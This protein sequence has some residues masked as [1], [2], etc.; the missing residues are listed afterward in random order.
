VWITAAALLQCKDSEIAPRRTNTKIY[1]RQDAKHAK[2]GIVFSFATFAPLREMFR[3]SAAASPRW[4]P[5]MH[6]ASQ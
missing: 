6:T 4:V 3:I 5:A 2:S 1:S